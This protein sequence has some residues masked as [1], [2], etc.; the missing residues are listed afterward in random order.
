MVTLAEATGL[1]RLIS[2]ENGQTTQCD[3]RKG[4]LCQGKQRGSGQEVAL[5]QK[6]ESCVGTSS[7]LDYRDVFYPGGSTSAIA[8]KWE[9]AGTV[10]SV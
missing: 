5:E 7:S 4:S 6:L 3:H 2:M 1:N 8:K 9:M 10:R